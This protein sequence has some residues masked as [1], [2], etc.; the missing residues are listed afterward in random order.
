MQKEA[1]ELY[2]DFTS[3]QNCTTPL[4]A[5]TIKKHLL[6]KLRHRCI[7]KTGKLRDCQ[8]AADGTSRNRK[9]RFNQV[10][11]SSPLDFTILRDSS[12]KHSFD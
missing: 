7:R 6:H 4:T 9:V 12:T 2:K 5:T 1:F 11:I 3:Q 10:K 8:T